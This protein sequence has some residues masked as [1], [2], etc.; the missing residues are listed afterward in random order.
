[1]LR[2]SLQMLEKSVKKKRNLTYDSAKQC[3]LRPLHTS[4]HTSLMISL[5]KSPTN[6]IT[7]SQRMHGYASAV[8]SQILP[9]N[10]HLPNRV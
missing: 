1:M 4:L 3:V 10:V 6:R 7:G 9:R 5:G 2:V 8:F